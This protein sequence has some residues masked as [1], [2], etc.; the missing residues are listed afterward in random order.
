MINQYPWAMGLKIPKDII[1]SWASQAGDSD[2]LRWALANAKLPEFGYQE[3]AKSYYQLP[4]LDTEFFD[5][6]PNPDLWAKWGNFA[7][8]G[9]FLPI[10]EWEGVLYIACLEPPSFEQSQLVEGLNQKVALVIAPMSGMKKWWS[11]LSPMAQHIGQQSTGSNLPPGLAEFSSG[12]VSSQS[13]AKTQE[14]PVQQVQTV[15]SFNQTPV[16][17]SVQNNSVPVNP[18]TVAP[19]TNSAPAQVEVPVAPVAHNN[20]NNVQAS[21]PESINIPTPEPVAAAQVPV[22]PPVPSAPVASAPV[23]EA[24]VPAV[25]SPVVEAVAAA[26]VSVPEPTPVVENIVP[27][28]N[29]GISDEI[30][31]EQIQSASFPVDI[32]DA[33]VLNRVEESHITETKELIEE[34]EEFKLDIPEAPEFTTTT[35]LSDNMNT[36]PPAIQIVADEPEEEA[37]DLNLST[38]NVDKSSLDSF[39]FEAM[40]AEADQHEPSAELDFELKLDDMDSQEKAV[41]EEAAPSVE[42]AIEGLEGIDLSG[43]SNEQDSEAGLEGL[44]LDLSSADANGSDVEGLD[45]SAMLKEDEAGGGLDLSLDSDSPSSQPPSAHLVPDENP[46]L[47]NSLDVVEPAA[48]SPLKVVHPEE[49]PVVAEVSPQSSIADVPVDASEE[50]RLGYRALSDLSQY[51]D[52]VMILQ[53][54]QM[55]LKPSLW[56]GN[57]HHNKNSNSN[58][59]ITMSSIFRIVFTSKKAYHG[60]VVR[61]HINDAFLNSFNQG[62]LPDHATLVPVLVDNNL[63]GILL[64]FT[65]LRKAEFVNLEDCERIADKYGSD[66]LELNRSKAQAA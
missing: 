4:S 1:S 49:T 63:V 44:N 45:F 16:V 11:I 15:E 12:G 58:I 22:P 66:L 56:Q 51:F 57:W 6:S 64:G 61:N 31:D 10:Y 13:Q 55:L 59:D 19:V 28:I 30:A 47:A 26:P 62:E 3:W 50:D 52:R 18:Q 2:L 41:V 43:D 60:Y 36:E 40:Q 21:V 23:V 33:P 20:A 8:S 65:D 5:Q 53:P 34:P 48:T 35:S 17:N 25:P 29:F 14:Q 32:P 37:L 42:E 54:H 7:W 38:E 46:V 9:T 39:D 27:D 24:V